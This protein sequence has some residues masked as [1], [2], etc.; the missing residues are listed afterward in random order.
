MSRL[1]CFGVLDLPWLRFQTARCQTY[2]LKNKHP[3]IK[4]LYLY[5]FS[6]RKM[7]RIWHQHRE[8]VNNIRLNS[9]VNCDELCLWISVVVSF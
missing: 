6:V 1:I 8:E 5:N 4:R 7:V 9:N 3:K 2:H